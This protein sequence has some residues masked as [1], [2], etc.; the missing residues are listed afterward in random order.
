METGGGSVYSNI[1]DLKDILKRILDEPGILE[2]WNQN[3]MSAYMELDYQK[4][5]QKITSCYYQ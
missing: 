1:N 5:V 4:Y 3:I 2:E